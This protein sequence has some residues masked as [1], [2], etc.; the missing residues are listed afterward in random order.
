MI[1]LKFYTI[2]EAASILKITPSTLYKYIWAGTIT[3]YHRIGKGRGSIRFTA[4]DIQN[5]LRKNGE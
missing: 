1:D 5:V 4:E 3:H 2:E